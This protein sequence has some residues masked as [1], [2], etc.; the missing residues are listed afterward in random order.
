MLLASR[1]NFGLNA[2]LGATCHPPRWLYKP[3]LRAPDN[4]KGDDCH[5]YCG[6]KEP[7]TIRSEEPTNPYIA[8]IACKDK[9]RREE[10]DEGSDHAQPKANGSDYQNAKNYG[11]LTEKAHGT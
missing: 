6:E 2:L 10:D 8:G 5:D 11:C 1:C 3:Q 9:R 7:E 4:W